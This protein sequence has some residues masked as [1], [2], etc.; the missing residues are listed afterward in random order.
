[1]SMV[2]GCDGYMVSVDTASVDTLVQLREE[3]HE[4][5]E[6][7]PN[8]DYRRWLQQEFEIVDDELDARVKEGT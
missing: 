1:M 5:I 4:R 8:G 3:L 6:S 7:L 2:Q